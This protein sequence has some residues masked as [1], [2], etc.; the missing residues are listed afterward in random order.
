[1]TLKAPNNGDVRFEHFVNSQK[2]PINFDEF[3][4]TTTNPFPILGLRLNS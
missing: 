1:M 2:K 3:S 4:Q